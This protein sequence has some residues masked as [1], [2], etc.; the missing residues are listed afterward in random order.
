MKM[1]IREILQKD[2]K[3]LLELKQDVE[4]TFDNSVKELVPY[5]SIILSRYFLELFNLYPDIKVTEDFLIHKFLINGSFRE[6]TYL[7]MLTSIIRYIVSHIEYKHKNKVAFILAKE[8]YKVLMKLNNE[9]LPNISNSFYSLDIMDFIEIQENENIK[10]ILSKLDTEEITDEL[11]KETYNNIENFIKNYDGPKNNLIEGIK[12]DLAGMN[13]IMQL[14]GPRGYVTDVDMTIFKYPI[15]RSFTQGLNNAYNLMV[16]SRSAAKA[17]YLS[18]KALSESEYLARKI[19]LMTLIVRNIKYGDCK[20]NEYLKWNVRPKTNSYQGDLKNLV[21]SYYLNEE[22]NTLEVIT[23]NHKHLE[24]KTIKIRNPIY[25][26]YKNKYHVCSTCFG[27]T[28]LGIPEYTNIGHMSGVVTTTKFSQSILSTKHLDTSSESFKIVI[29]E[30]YKKY[31]TTNRD[32]TSFKLKYNKRFKDVKLYIPFEDFNRI[33]EIETLE[34]VRKVNIYRISFLKEVILKY[35]EKDKENEVILDLTYDKK[36]SSFH[37]DFL[38]YVVENGFE[39]KNNYIIVN[40]DKWDYDKILSVVKKKEKSHSQVVGELKS[41]IETDNN[42]EDNTGTDTLES[43]LSRLFDVVN[44]K[45]SVNIAYL[46]ILTYAKSSYGGDKEYDLSRGS[47]YPRLSSLQ[48]NIK[49]R[50]FS[51]Q[52]PFDNLHNVMLEPIVFNPNNRPNHPLD[53]VINTEECLEE[54]SKLIKKIK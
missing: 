28:S 7:N 6:K 2:T 43:F 30:V 32:K 27:D 3:D 25:C 4:V 40:M 8:C 22:T 10:N 52:L 13:K 48:N 16:E 19:Q 47:K 42:S 21:G 23:E 46:S 15:L 11:I 37:I 51:A 18:T 24:G 33:T 35:K 36:T 41:L 50:S 39:I 45:V 26:K 12:C 54:R 44:S 34:D 17:L 14:I 1:H 31:L 20:S 49:R 53:V 5:K 38:S 29:P 9:F